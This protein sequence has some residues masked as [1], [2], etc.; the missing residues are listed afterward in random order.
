MMAIRFQTAHGIRPRG[1]ALFGFSVKGSRGIR[2]VLGLVVALAMV[3]LGTSALA[4]GPALTPAHGHAAADHSGTHSSG[5]S[6]DLSVTTTSGTTTRVS[7]QQKSASGGSWQRSE[8][9]RGRTSTDLSPGKSSDR[10]IL[11]SFSSAKRRGS[12]TTS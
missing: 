11:N 10:G 8:P 6:E 7:S 4:E 5:T 12:S 9:W 3:A 1:A 2:F